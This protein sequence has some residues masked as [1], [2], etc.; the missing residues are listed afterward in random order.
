[1]SDHA[2]VV[3]FYRSYGTESFAGAAPLYAQVCSELGDHPGLVAL[4][5]K[6]DPEAQQPNLLFAAVH[7]LLLSGLNH[8][9][10]QIYDGTVDEPVTP[11]FADLV[12]TNRAAIDELLRTRRTQTNEVGRAA[13]LALMLSDASKRAK[14][15]LAWID[16]G[17]SGGLN[18]N[19]DQ[20]RI[21]YTMGE[22]VESTGP[23]DAQ[24]T[25]QCEVRS[26]SPDVAADHPP[27]SWR[28]GIDRAPIDVT[29]TAE[30]RW[31]Q[32]CLWPSQPEH[33]A[34]LAAA[35][36]V[37]DRIPP[38]LIAAEAADGLAKA[39][40]QAPAGTALVVTTSW[41]W[42]YLPEPTRQAVLAMMAASDRRVHWYSL[43]A[44]GVV[45]ELGYEGEPSVIDSVVGR[46]ELGGG[47]P[48]EAAVLGRSHP[49]GAW[50]EWC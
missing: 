11:A 19:T 23:A 7:Y 21:D 9:L 39:M 37:A 8:P 41:V 12:V 43:E 35:I 14:Q 24:L 13:I 27:I 20:F 28:V 16:L 17:A 42:F 45:D 31:L 22:Q 10:L 46:V 26:G 38:R 50:L 34:R 33:Q 15:P 48:I 44:A 36:E 29:N 18:L 5:A 6:H 25:L 30:A 1:M 32:A 40:A 2:E 4:I 3:D 47:E 49:H